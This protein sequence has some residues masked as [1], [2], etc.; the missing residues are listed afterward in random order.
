MPSPRASEG[1]NT[2]LKTA[3]RSCSGQASIEYLLVGLALIATI[4]ALGVVW[5][6]LSGS[7]VLELVASGASHS[8]STLGGVADVFA[9]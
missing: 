4:A 3:W 8:L 1:S 5:R 2:M 6:Y 9:Y 7:S